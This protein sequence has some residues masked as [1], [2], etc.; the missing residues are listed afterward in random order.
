MRLL[1]AAAFVLPLLV[2]A[3]ASAMFYGRRFDDAR[4]RLSRTLDIAHEHAV[5]VF[6]TLDLVRSQVDQ[7]VSGLSDDEIRRQERSIH[8]RLKSLSDALDQISG[9]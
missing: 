5:K 8:L 4:D 9:I 3:I 2:F 1:V 7:A 6:E